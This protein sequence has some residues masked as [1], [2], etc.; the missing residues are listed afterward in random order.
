MFLKKEFHFLK[1]TPLN[2]AAFFPIVLF[3]YLFFRH[4]KNPPLAFFF[5]TLFTLIL[6]A[7]AHLSINNQGFLYVAVIL[8][9]HATPLYLL[10]GPSF[11]L[12]IR[13]SLY[14]KKINWR[15]SIHIIP[16]L[17]QLVAI[18]PYIFVPISEK[19]EIVQ[20]IIAN[21]MIQKSLTFNWLFSTEFVYFFRSLHFIVYLIS[22]LMLIHKTESILDFQ[23]QKR[24]KSLKRISWI[25][26]SLTFVY[27]VHII[28]VAYGNNYRDWLINT[29]IACD[30]FLFTL[31]FVELSKHP[32][33]LYN[34]DILRRRYLKASPFLANDTRENLLPPEIALEIESSI[35]KLIREKKFFSNSQSNFDSFAR[36]IGQSKYHI[37]SFLKS[38][39]TSF[40]VL[41]NLHRIEI[42]KELLE[43][44]RYYKIEYI[45]H[46]SGFDSLSNFFKLFKNTVECTPDEYRKTKRASWAETNQ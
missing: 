3:I 6:H 10:A 25:L 33:L 45:A 13:S 11:Y 22:G 28:L 18:V 14:Q 34:S 19:L 15:D 35:N 16:A 30:F 38:Q 39:N 37:R 42:A 43:A 40:M 17:I 44:K 29:A 9:V 1:K 4:L 23:E 7:I 5:F 46:K 26:I 27:S 2:T 31:L 8:F 20:S 36:A 21:P 41:K 32:E 12:F 24:L